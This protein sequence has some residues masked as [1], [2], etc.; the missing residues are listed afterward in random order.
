[1]ER[2]GLHLALDALRP[3][4]HWV[5]PP[6]DTRRFDTRFF[7]AHLPPDQEPEHDAAETVESVWLTAAGA[8]DLARSGRIVLPPPTWITLRE[9][10]PFATVDAIFDAAPGRDLGRREPLLV[11]AEGTRVLIMPGDP[12]HPG[13]SAGAHVETRF[14][15]R[16]GLWHATYASV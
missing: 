5:T 4:A 1:M 15:W 3:F 8:I 9:L 16:D 6:V 14:V 12:Q 7:I 2:E 10:E 11:Q 13:T